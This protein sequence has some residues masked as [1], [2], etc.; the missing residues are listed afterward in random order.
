MRL[1]MQ[2]NPGFRIAGLLLSI[3][4]GMEE[5]IRHTQEIRDLVATMK[6]IPVKELLQKPNCSL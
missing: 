6:L 4:P 5:A 3:P 2:W 1:V